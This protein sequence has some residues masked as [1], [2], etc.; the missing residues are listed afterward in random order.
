M[1]TNVKPNICTRCDHHWYSTRFDAGGRPVLA[2]KC[3]K[4]NSPYWDKPRMSKADRAALV[5]KK[6]R[7]YHR[8]KKAG[9]RV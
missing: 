1:P 5:A 2:K 4:C 6:T 8:A 7:A 3:P 9:E